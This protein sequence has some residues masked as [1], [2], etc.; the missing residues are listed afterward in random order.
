MNSLDLTSSSK[1]KLKRDSEHS[2]IRKNIRTLRNSFSSEEQAIAAEALVSRILIDPD[3]QNAEKLAFYQAFDGEINP[4]LALQTAL[5]LGKRC[6]LPLINKTDSSMLFVE[7]N[8]QSSLKQNHYGILEPE[9]YPDRTLASEYLD[10]IF[11][12]LVAFDD[13]GTRLG[14]GLGYYDRNLAFLRGNAAKSRQ[15]SPKLIGLAYECQRVDELERAEW[16][17][18]L[19]KIITD[20]TTYLINS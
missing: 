9:L 1:K 14:M 3:F 13:K 16:D 6:F 20:Q 4:S 18:P 15:K 19:D 5:K 2:Q 10:T 7:F 8:S 17:I 12:P 11:M